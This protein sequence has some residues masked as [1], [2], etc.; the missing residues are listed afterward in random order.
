MPQSLIKKSRFLSLILR[1]KPEVIGLTLD[2]NGWVDIDT[3]LAAAQ[4]HNRPFTRTELDE[5]VATNNKKRFAISEDGKRIR[6]RQGHSLHVDLELQPRTP[7]P[8][9]YHGTAVC[10]LPSIRE[11]G[12][13][14]M[15]RQHVHLS[16]TAETAHSVGSRHGKPAILLVQADDMHTAGYP[17]FLSENGVWLTDHVPST[18]LHELPS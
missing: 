9:L 7:P 8:V 12:L 15:N 11:Q 10:F 17:F 18:Y 13:Q 14:K 1:H 5:I 4:T 3:L 6:A 2:D 16:A